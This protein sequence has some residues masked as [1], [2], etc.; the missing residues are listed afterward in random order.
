ML[1]DFRLCS[2]LSPFLPSSLPDIEA[3]YSLD[4]CMGSGYIGSIEM[5]L[6]DYEKGHLR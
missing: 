6:Y 1:Y 2:E 5:H 3:G 4:T